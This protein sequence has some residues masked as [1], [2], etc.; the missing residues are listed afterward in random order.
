MHSA[1]S[2]LASVLPA[3][4]GKAPLTQDKVAFAWRTAAGEA[5][6]RWTRVTL[7][8][9]VLHVASDDERWLR[10]I[11]RARGTLLAR[12]RHLLGADA[13]RVIKTGPE[14]P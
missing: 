4:I 6:A 3:L 7:A 1:A 5:V 9:G 11:D 13:V 2:L 10:E 8:D 12:L 14:E